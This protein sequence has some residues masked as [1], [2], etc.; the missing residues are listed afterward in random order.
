[1]KRALVL[2]TLFATPLFAADEVAR[3]HALFDKSWETRLRENPMFATSVGR[4]E[5]DD[6]LTS[7]TPADLARRHEQAKAALA[8]LD[9]IDRSALPP[10]ERVNADIFRRQLENA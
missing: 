5:Y 9:A 3:L 8:T 10:N 4:H 7:R 1:M 6:K 2:M